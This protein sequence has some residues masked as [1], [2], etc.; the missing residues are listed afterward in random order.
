MQTQTPVRWSL[1]V[2]LETD[3]ELRTYLA[4]QGMRKG[5]LSKF[6]EQAVRRDIFAR[7]LD[8]VHAQNRD[9]DSETLEVAIAAALAAQRAQVSRNSRTSS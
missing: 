6:V 7:T 1:K 4:Q 5:D 9:V 2:S 3:I 8:E